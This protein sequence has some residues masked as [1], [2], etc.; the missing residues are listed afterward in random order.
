MLFFVQIVQTNNNES[1]WK[2]KKNN[3]LEQ[4]SEK[5]RIWQEGKKKLIKKI[6]LTR[7]IS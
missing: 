3:F 1:N 6:W 5:M 4:T 2:E 7:Y